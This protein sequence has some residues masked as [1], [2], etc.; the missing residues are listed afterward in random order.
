MIEVETVQAAEF[1]LVHCGLD[2]SFVAKAVHSIAAMPLALDDLADGAFRLRR[3][4]GFDI[5]FLLARDDGRVVA[6]ILRVWPV[7]ESDRMRKVLQ[8]IDLLAMLRG[9]AGV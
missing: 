8:G 3:I 6:T 4:D 9:A 1:D 5:V 2:D 7:R